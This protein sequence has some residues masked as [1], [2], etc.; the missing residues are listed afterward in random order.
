[1]RRTGGIVRFERAAI[2]LWLST[3]AMLSRHRTQAD[4]DHLLL[5][6]AEKHRMWVTALS[7]AIQQVTCKSNHFRLCMDVLCM[8]VLCV[9]VMMGFSLNMT[10]SPMQMQTT[11][12]VQFV[13]EYVE[14]EERLQ[15]V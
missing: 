7:C 9:D 4:F 6:L 5:Y 3:S 8:F 13:V 14:S 11:A 10:N 1:M 2:N 15:V 12:A